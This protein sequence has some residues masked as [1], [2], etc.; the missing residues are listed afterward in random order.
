MCFDDFDRKSSSFD[1]NEIFGFI[2]YLVE[3]RGVKVLIISN[4]EELIKD[5]NYTESIREK[6]IGVSITYAPNISDIFD[7]IIDVKYRSSEGLYYSVLAA[8][9]STILHAIESNKNN[10][11][12]LLFFFGKIQSDLWPS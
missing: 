1:V 2:N 4:E 10:L 12:N 8:H 9:K 7:Q 11:R 3:D 5:P 6:V